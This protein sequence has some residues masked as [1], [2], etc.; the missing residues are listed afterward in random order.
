MAEKKTLV[1]RVDAGGF[2]HVG[3]KALAFVPDKLCAFR[4][5]LR[6]GSFIHHSSHHVMKV[7]RIWSAVGICRPAVRVSPQT[8][9]TARAASLSAIHRGLRQSEKAQSGESRDLEPYGSRRPDRIAR[10]AKSL[11]G[12]AS[13]RQQ[14]KLKK[15]LARKAEE[16][17]TE[18]EEG[19][20]RQT[21]RKRFL[22][23]NSDFG[24]KSIVYQIRHGALKDK[25]A[26]LEQPVQAKSFRAIHRERRAAQDSP[27]SEK[28]GGNGSPHERDAHQDAALEPNG[29]RR[30]RPMMPM[31]VKY[32]TAASQ[33]LYGKSV[34]KCALEQGRRSL[35]H[36][37]IYGGDSRK[38]AK[39]KENAAMLRL[40]AARGVPTTTVANE[41]QRLMDK[42]SMGRPHNGF[43]L[44][45]SPLP[46]LPVKSLGRVEE[47]PGR[48]G[49]HVERDFQTKE[50][51]SINGTESFVPRSSHIA[52]KPFVLLL[53]EI[54]DPGNL[55]G[56]IRTASYLGIDA[57]AI[58]NRT[59]TKLTS[60]VLKA[61]AG[62]AEEV[63]IFTVESAE[64]FLERSKKAG[65]KTY[66]AVAPPD[67]K[68]VR[69]HGGKFVSMDMVERDNPL[70]K[71]PCVLTLGNEGHGLSKTIKVAADY[72]L[73]VPRFAQSSSVD[74]LNVS[75]AA[76]L[77]CH[78]FVR[79]PPLQSQPDHGLESHNS[80]PL[81]ERRPGDEERGERRTAE[82]EGEKMF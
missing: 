31:T 36:L 22:D 35:Y 52:P 61:A 54:L 26:Q 41:E 39:D 66:A 58:T 74:S 40:A 63:T 21:R 8:P 56:L 50:E 20:A 46:Q 57:V 77:L 11:A 44:E 23:P 71:H 5:S 69:R 45:A 10:T 47:T 38:A 15:K 19:T 60:V 14:H 13:P 68:L 12:C 7:P 82:Q 76:G 27:T 55:G 16:K 72:E 67:R 80:A 64:T 62:A 3:S 17:R 34:V 51:E 1:V 30:R 33:F 48:Q 53:N 81:G 79:Q 18:R 78:A 59:S 75:V 24:K 4:L 37:Y 43:V 70:S 28:D 73:S 9:P 49:F 32:T 2:V 42:M 6:L 65:W 25:A 29:P